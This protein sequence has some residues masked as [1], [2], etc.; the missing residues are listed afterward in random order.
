M[1]SPLLPYPSLLLLSLRGEGGESPTTHDVRRRRRHY[2]SS[3]SSSSSSVMIPCR[4][5]S[6]WA[7]GAG[8]VDHNNNGGDIEMGMAAKKLGA[9]EGAIE[10]RSVLKGDELLLFNKY[11]KKAKGHLTP[12]EVFKLKPIP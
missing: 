8:S 10:A 7:N 3:S 2:L 5:F 11:D 9:I 6:S 1:A 12:M 4:I